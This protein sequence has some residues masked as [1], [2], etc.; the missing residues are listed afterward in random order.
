MEFLLY[1]RR[2]ENLENPSRPP[3]TVYT[4]NPAP[5]LRGFQ[6]EPNPSVPSE[7]ELRGRLQKLRQRLTTAPS[8][9]EME[10]RLAKLQGMPMKSKSQSFGNTYDYRTLDIKCSHNFH[11]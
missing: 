7:Q 11:Q 4:Q 3:V 8:V 9:E 5:A 2:I 1:F 10:E 6:V